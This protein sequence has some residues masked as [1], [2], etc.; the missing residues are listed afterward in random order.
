MALSEEDEV[1]ARYGNAWSLAQVAHRKY[2]A[3][4]LALALTGVSV[5]TTIAIIVSI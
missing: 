2:A 1:K 5:A 3:L 4:R